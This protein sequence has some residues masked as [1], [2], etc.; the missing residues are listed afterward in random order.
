LAKTDPGQGSRGAPFGVHRPAIR[1]HRLYAPRWSTGLPGEQRRRLDGMADATRWGECFT[2]R[3]ARC[4]LVSLIRAVGHSSPAFP[5]PGGDAVIQVPAGWRRSV[6]RGSPRRRRRV[7]RYQP[8]PG[9]GS[10]GAPFAMDDPAIRAAASYRV[11]ALVAPSAAIR[12]TRHSRTSLSS[13]AQIP[14]PLCHVRWLAGCWRSIAP[15]RATVPG[16][17]GYPTCSGRPR[18]RGTSCR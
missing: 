6:W 16:Y 4:P 2:G 3:D 8:N 13:Q 12:K 11:A 15:Q 1:A 14:R 18:H 5:A 17:I 7:L 10:R 9:H